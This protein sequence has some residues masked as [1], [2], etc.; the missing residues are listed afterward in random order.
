MKKTVFIVTL[1][2]A[3]IALLS[4]RAMPWGDEWGTAVQEAGT[5]GDNWQSAGAA[6]SGA[7]ADVSAAAESGTVTYVQ[8]IPVA[9]TFYNGCSLAEW[10]G[11][12]NIGDSEAKAMLESFF[13]SLY[14]H[15]S[16]F[17]EY[18]DGEQ[19]CIQDYETAKANWVSDLKQY[20]PQHLYWADNMRLVTSEYEWHTMTAISPNSQFNNPSRVYIVDARDISYRGTV[21]T[22]DGSDADTLRI[23]TSYSMKY[24][25][26][27]EDG[28]LLSGEEATTII[29]GTPS[30]TFAAGAVPD[31]VTDNTVEYLINHRSEVIHDHLTGLPINTRE[32]YYQSKVDPDIYY[33][34]ESYDLRLSRVERERLATISP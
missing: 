22:F 8:G 31:H 14:L 30:Q 1:C 3:A 15:E 4:G 6:A 29:E 27:Y 32:T 2:I 34:K 24:G 5:V 11:I 18:K 19:Q 21:T 12:S 10:T 17:P 7:K 13:A 33:S 20:D 28:K 23:Y 25:K 16:A 26:E 9:R